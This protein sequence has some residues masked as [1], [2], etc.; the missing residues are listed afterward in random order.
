[1]VISS[2]AAVLWVLWRGVLQR[3]ETALIAVWPDAS[4]DQAAVVLACVN[5]RRLRRW[6]AA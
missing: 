3:G 6:P 1:M 2:P 5:P 4:L